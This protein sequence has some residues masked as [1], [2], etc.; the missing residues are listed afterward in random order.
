MAFPDLFQIFSTKPLLEPVL[1]NCYSFGPIG[2]NSSEILLKIKVFSL[3]K[4]CKIL[5]FEF[6]LHCVNLYALIL[7]LNNH[8]THV[9]G[10]VYYWFCFYVTIKC[11]KYWLKEKGLYMLNVIPFLWTEISPAQ[12]HHHR[13]RNISVYRKWRIM[14]ASAM[15]QK[16]VSQMVYKFMIKTCKSVCCSYIKKQ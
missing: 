10:I 16:P 4:V 3:T 11:I 5:A 6:R 13:G 9:N 7:D 2:T 15:N 14:T 8:L 1:T 12:I